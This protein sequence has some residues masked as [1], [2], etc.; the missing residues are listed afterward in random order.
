M[1]VTANEVSVDLFDA[2]R[3][4]GQKLEDFKVVEEVTGGEH[5][6]FKTTLRFAGKAADEETTYLVIGIDPL[7]VFRAEDYKRTTGM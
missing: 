7:N 3:Q 4:A 1:T 5:P 2:R 6:A